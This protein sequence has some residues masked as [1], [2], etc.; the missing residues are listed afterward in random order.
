M[1]GVESDSFHFAG[2]WLTAVGGA[3]AGVLCV[4]LPVLGTAVSLGALGT[5]AL[6]LLGDLAAGLA[7][8]A[9]SLHPAVAGSIAAAIAAA[10]V[11]VFSRSPTIHLMGQTLA[12]ALTGA[13]LLAF[14]AD[15]VLAPYEVTR[16]APPHLCAE[17]TE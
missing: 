9:F 7:E 15:I 10:V 8:T 6:V 12:R 13:L 17:D 3:S 5:L 11:C 16:A 2:L 14:A 4:L 1:S